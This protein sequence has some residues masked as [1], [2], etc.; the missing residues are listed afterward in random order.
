[1]CVFSF[2]F[3]IYRSKW[4]CFLK[5]RNNHELITEKTMD[6]FMITEKTVDI[7]GAKCHKLPGEISGLFLCPLPPKLPTKR[8]MPV[9]L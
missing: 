9:T 3:D 1:M 6:I 8:K 2:S 4:F 7:L 5:K